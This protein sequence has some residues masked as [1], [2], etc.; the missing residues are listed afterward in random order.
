PPGDD[1]PVLVAD[2]DEDALADMRAAVA[3][4]LPGIEVVTARDGE[5]AWL[6][7]R[8]RPPRLAILDLMMPGATGTELVARFRSDERLRSVPI[9]LMTNKVVSTEDLRAIEGYS[10]IAL[11]NKGVW[12]EEDAAAG[13]ARLAGG[14]PPLPAATSAVVKRCIAYMNRYFATAVTRW[15]LAEA[16]NVS[17]DYLSRIF[18][19]ELGITPWE[20][21]SRLRVKRAKEFLAA[22]SESVALVGER[23]GFPDQAYFSRVFRKVAGM[24]PQAYRDTAGKKPRLPHQDQRT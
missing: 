4:A 15:K 10:R 20:Y 2:D 14:D 23:V 13:I 21:L 8:S 5:K 6:A 17:E 11:H 1:E 22:G 19:R 7:A 18:R 24:S 3:R 9:L 12:T 16:V